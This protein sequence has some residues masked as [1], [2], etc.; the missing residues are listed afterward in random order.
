M[1]HIDFEAET[2]HEARQMALENLG[3]SEDDVQIE[4][5]NKEKRGFWGIGKRELAKVRVYYKEDGNFNHIMDTIKGLIQ[6]LEPNIETEV[7]T[8]DDGKYIVNVKASQGGHLIGK[9]GKALNSIQAIVNA[10]LKRYENKYK[11]MIDVDNYHQRQK[12]NILRLAGSTAKRVQ[13]NRRSVLMKPMNPFERRLVHMEL[14][15]FDGIQS[16]SQGD[17]RFKQIKVFYVSNEF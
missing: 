9:N 4:V 3:L 6:V 12:Q 10:Y 7:D 1:L 13:G 17:G 2:E 11:I 14:K 8:S 5:L 16:E 15:K